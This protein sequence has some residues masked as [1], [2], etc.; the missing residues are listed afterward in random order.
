MDPCD[1][2]HI[3]SARAAKTHMPPVNEPASPVNLS[4]LQELK[5]AQDKTDRLLAFNV[6]TQSP[7]AKDVENSQDA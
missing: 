4:P 7:S 6:C 5:V 1:R 2:C 3:L